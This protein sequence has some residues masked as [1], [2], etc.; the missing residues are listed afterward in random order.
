MDVTSLALGYQDILVRSRK[1]TQILKKETVSLTGKIQEFAE[2]LQLGKPKEMRALMSALPDR[3]EVVVTFLAS[4]ELSRLRKLRLHQDVTYSPIWLELIET[5]ENFN[6][7]ATGS[8]FEY[9]NER[10]PLPEGMTL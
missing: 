9:A 10:T 5:L 3:P 7:E 6:L 8:G 4:L 2:R 1:R